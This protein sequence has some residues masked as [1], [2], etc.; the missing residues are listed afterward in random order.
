M[1]DPIYIQSFSTLAEKT[2]RG[3]R[4]T[5]SLLFCIRT[6][7]TDRQTHRLTDRRTDGCKISA[8]SEDNFTVA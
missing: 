2:V 7:R 4:D 1:I 8:I 6:G 3:F 5:T